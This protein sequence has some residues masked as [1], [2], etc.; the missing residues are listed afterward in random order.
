MEDLEHPVVGHPIEASS[1]CLGISTLLAYS[2]YSKHERDDL[3][4]EQVR[5]LRRVVEAEFP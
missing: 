1:P 5:T 4:A 2:I 3:S